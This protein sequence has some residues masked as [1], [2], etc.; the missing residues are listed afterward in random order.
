MYNRG[1]GSTGGTPSKL[2]AGRNQ[3]SGWNAPTLGN[4]WNTEG[5]PSYTASSLTG[6]FSLGG[7]GSSAGVGQSSLDDVCDVCGG[8]MF[9]CFFLVPFTLIKPLIEISFTCSLYQLKL[10]KLSK[11]FTSPWAVK[12][13]API[14]T[15]YV[16]IPP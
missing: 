14:I 10:S 11:Y 2:S 8:P 15:I 12:Y 3:G 16:A 6:G 5:T 13:K 9:V 1:A 7:A 4:T